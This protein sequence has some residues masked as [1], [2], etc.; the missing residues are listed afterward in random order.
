MLMSR[1]CHLSRES[2]EHPEK[3]GLHTSLHRELSVIVHIVEVIM[4]S[5]HR[6]SGESF[7]HVIHI[8]LLELRW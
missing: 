8:Y 4:E 7:T 2:E 6:I 3:G 1:S 5:G